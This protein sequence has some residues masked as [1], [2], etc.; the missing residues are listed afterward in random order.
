MEMPEY[1]SEGLKET[2]GSWKTYKQGS[3][4]DELVQSL[5]G[6]PLEWCTAN[7]DTARTQLRGGDF[8]VYYSINEN[9]EAIIPRVA[10]R[11]EEGNIGEVRGIAANQNMDPYI[12][13]VVKEKMSGFPDGKKYEKKSEDMKRLTEIEEKNNQ[14]IELSKED[15]RFLYEIDSKIAGFGYQ[16]DPRIEEITSK[17]DIR[18]DL[19]LATGFKEDEISLSQEEALNE[20]IKYHQGAIDLKGIKSAE[21]LNLPRYI[22]GDLNLKLLES[23]ES[24]N[25]P[26]SISGKLYLKGIKSAEGLILPQFIGR[27]IYLSGLRSAKDLTL[28]EFIGRNLSLDK[29]ESAEGLVLP[30]FVSGSL[31]L[32]SLESAKYLNLPQSIGA[33]LNLN[34][35][36]STEGLNLPQSIGGDLYLE[37]LKPA[38]LEEIKNKY[39]QHKISLLEL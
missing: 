37:D 30:Q 33:N 21:G 11:M 24:L 23:A 13:D 31:Y 19:S 36:K 16:E 22:S 14:A 2:R 35:L 38:E 17:R 25:L 15:L 39:P 18:S 6:H 3:E 9:G 27:D 28:P 29:L 34:S 7:I 1:S 5:D 4:P 32:D 8:H 10:I 20:G 26:E 12:G